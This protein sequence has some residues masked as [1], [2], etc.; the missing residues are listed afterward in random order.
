MSRDSPAEPRPLSVSHW[1]VLA[2]VM[3]RSS[4]AYEIG[5]RYRRRFGSFAPTAPNA[6]YGT[7]DRLFDRGFIAE[8]LVAQH[9]RRRGRRVI[10]RATPEGILAHRRWLLSSIKPAFWRVELLARI[11]T[12]SALRRSELLALL[13]LYEQ[14]I[15]QHNRGIYAPQ[16]LAAQEDP[17][18]LI[19]YE[20]LATT[21]AQLNWV[22][23][24]RARLQDMP[25]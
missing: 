2:L 8:S 25:L 18:Q 7:C 6:V 9:P 1:L 13:S 10:Y 15:R 5:D 23:T 4:H 3:E 21:T 14:M 24:T 22:K 11:G 12:S 16:P 19:A 17:R 20:Q